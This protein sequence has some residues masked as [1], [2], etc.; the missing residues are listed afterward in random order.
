VVTPCTERLDAA[1]FSKE[2]FAIKGATSRGISLVV[3]ATAN[4]S[5]L[6]SRRNPRSER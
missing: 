3:P 1:G 5:T 2:F 6:F 4:R